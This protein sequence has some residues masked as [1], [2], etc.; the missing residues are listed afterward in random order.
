[1]G[2][3]VWLFSPGHAPRVWCNHHDRLW[4]RCF[5]NVKLPTYL[6]AHGDVQPAHTA[7]QTPEVEES[8][9]AGGQAG[10]TGSAPAIR[11]EEEQ[12]GW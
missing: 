9:Q 4:G 6:C 8:P 3:A 11:V 1:M 7:A 5:I 10:Q 12:R 2:S